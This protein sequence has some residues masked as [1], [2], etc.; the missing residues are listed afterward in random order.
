MVSLLR[1]NLVNLEVADAAGDLGQLCE[2]LHRSF[3]YTT[4]D[5]SQRFS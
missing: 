5:I 1:I 4:A 3:R 2:S